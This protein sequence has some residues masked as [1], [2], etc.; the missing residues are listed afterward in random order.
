[1]DEIKRINI[2]EFRE[3]GFLQELNRVFLHPMGLALEVIINEDGTETLGGIWDYREDPEGMSFI[4][5]ST[6]EAKEKAK[7]VAEHATKKAI[8]R[9][10]ILGFVL[11]PIGHKFTE[12]EIK[13]LQE[14]KKERD[15]E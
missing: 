6:D 13:D 14:M 8:D 1:M 12:G 15:N 7:R 5:L 11:Q 4:D 10:E 3:F 2:K 9:M